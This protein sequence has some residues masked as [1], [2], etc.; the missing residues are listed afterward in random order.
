MKGKKTFTTAEA[1]AIRQLIRNKLVAPPA[2]QKCIRAEIRRL[3]FFI[4][5][6][7]NK[8][9]YTVEDF[10]QHVKIRG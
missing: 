2:E 1:R 6:F 3:G 8:K 9:R 5:D 4:T 7:S 10:D